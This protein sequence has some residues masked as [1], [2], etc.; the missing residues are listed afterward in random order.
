MAL[1][2]ID[3]RGLKTPI[4]LL[5]NEKI[6]FGTGNDLSIYHNGSHS[7]IEDGGTGRLIAK[8]SYFEVDNAAGN[9]AIIE[10]IED[11][12]VNL[13]YDGSKKL[14]TT[15]WGAKVTGNFVSV[16]HTKAHLN[17]TYDLGDASTRWRDI[18]VG[19]DIDILDNGKI[20]LGDGNDLQ[21][22][23][24]G[25][26]SIIADTGTGPLLLQSNQFLVYNNDGSELLIAANENGDAELYYDSSVKLETTSSGAKVTGTLEVT[27]DYVTT[28]Q[29]GYDFWIDK[30]GNKVQAGDGIKFQC[31][32]SGDLQIYHDGSHSYI[33]NGTGSL[34]IIGTAGADV[35][36]RNGD[37][38]ANVAVFNIDGATHLYYD[39]SHKFST[40]SSGVDIIGNATI[41][42][43]INTS[44][45]QNINVG[46]GGDLKIYHNGS[47]SY[48]DETGAGD[49]KI[50][51]SSGIQLQN[52]SEKYIACVPD[53]QV[54]L[55]HD[56][57]KKFQTVSYGAQILNNGNAQLNIRDT[58]ATAVAA[59]ISA[60][61]AGK[62]EYNCY[63]EGVGTKY[64]HVFVGYTTEYARI[65]DA[66][67]KFNG[68]T[69]TANALHDYEEGTWVLADN[70]GANVSMTAEHTAQ[71]TKIGRH[72][73][74]QADVTVGN[75]STGNHARFNLPFTAMNY[76]G[77]VINY[78]DYDSTLVIHAGGNGA[79]LFK[80][81]DANAGFSWSELANKRIIFGF[82]YTAS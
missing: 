1:T 29:T 5:D 53:G 23:H 37:D 15:S 72:V 27:E 65:D 11:G 20:L 21:I 56:N 24:N 66:G 71:Y 57:A 81:A 3:D 82:T 75:N 59:Y 46:N 47:D 6:R 17:N 32:N 64:P 70:T 49:L 22:Y 68:D 2:K 25:S 79:Y 13:Y 73:H 10:G 33:K 48:I 54:E 34:R 67:I 31:G 16:G 44:D 9:E 58:S 62:V 55:Y 19:N 18:Y 39:S 45:N 14:E 7:Y 12:A 60:I 38:T 61:T 43:A 50:R 69:A 51:S 74:V 36:I 78:T 80:G 52:S 28:M 35:T 40:S 30:S 42:G 4:D 77:G 26:Q 63:K 8:T 76:A 41:S